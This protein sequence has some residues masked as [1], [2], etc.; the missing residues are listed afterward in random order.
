MHY[1]ENYFLFADILIL[2]KNKSETISAIECVEVNSEANKYELEIE[3]NETIPFNKNNNS[4]I[5]NKKNK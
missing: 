4:K 1:Q 5:F 2:I 3:K